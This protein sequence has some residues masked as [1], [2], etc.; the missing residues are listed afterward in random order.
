MVSGDVPL[1]FLFKGA[2]TPTLLVSGAVSPYIGGQWYS[3]PLNVVKIAITLYIGG[4]W[5][6]TP[7]MMVASR[8]QPSY[9]PGQ[10]YRDL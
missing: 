10:W 7:F 5:S 2:A 1:T 3:A 8:E 4:Q 9:L 6:T